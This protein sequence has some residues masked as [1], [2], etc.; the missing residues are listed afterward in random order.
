MRL[1]KQ[2]LIFYCNGPSLMEIEYLSKAQS[3]PIDLL[4]PY[5]PLQHGMGMRLKKATQLQ[6][7]S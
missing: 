4:M 7:L 6:A 5:L 2:Q 3:G 1:F